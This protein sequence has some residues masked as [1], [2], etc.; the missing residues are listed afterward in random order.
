MKNDS[1]LQ[2]DL[3]EEMRWDPQLR[4]CEIGVAVRDG[5]VTLSG[6]VST[7]AKKLAAERAT[8]RVSGVRAVADDLVVN[9]AGSLRRTDTEIAH[10]AVNALAWNTEVPDE[11]VTIKVDNGWITLEGSV[12]WRFHADAAERAVRYLMGVKGVTNMLLVVPS[13]SAIDVRVKIEQALKRSAD[14]DSKRI[15]VEALDGKVTLK[16]TVRSW[17]ER[18]DAESAAWAAPGVKQVEDNILVSA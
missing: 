10:A 7:Y 6:A 12:P 15:S 4:D 18:R 14:I 13:V 3:F 11:K 9:F 2:R 17:T 1:Q 8:E 5:V 16:G